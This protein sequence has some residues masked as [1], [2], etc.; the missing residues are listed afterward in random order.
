MLIKVRNNTYIINEQNITT[1][2][3]ASRFANEELAPNKISIPYCQTQ[4]AKNLSL[5]DIHKLNI[6]WGVFISKS[7]VE[8]ANFKPDNNWKEIEIEFPDKKTKGEETV[9]GYIGH[10]LRF[11]VLSRSPQ[12][13]HTKNQNGYWEF[14][15]YYADKIDNSTYGEK[16]QSDKANY[17]SIVRLLI[18]FLDENNQPLH[19]TPFS[20]KT[21]GGIRISLNRSLDSYYK[22]VETSFYQAI[23]QPIKR[24]SNK[25]RSKIIVDF[26]L[27]LNRNG[28]TNPYIVIKSRTSPSIEIGKQSDLVT[29]NRNNGSSSTVRLIGEKLENIFV[30]ENS[31]LEQT[32]DNFL[33]I[34]SDFG[35]ANKKIEEPKFTSSEIAKIKA[36]L[37]E[38]DKVEKIIE[39][40][41]DSEIP[42]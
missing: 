30:E 18:L 14:G 12:E 9:T 41:D 22:E 39:E 17:E 23:S 10:K 28:D 21:K 27:D 29:V 20:Y 11:V 19:D 8:A 33:K 7:Q 5:K 16:V 40:V 25:A 36:D 35:Q 42:F 32:I 6:P 15:G 34:Y 38:G 24:L 31:Q 37:F 1:M 2:F 4:N 26:Q 3:N 13:I